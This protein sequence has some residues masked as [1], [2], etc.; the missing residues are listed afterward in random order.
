MSGSSTRSFSVTSIFAEWRKWTWPVL[1]VLLVGSIGYLV[2]N[3]DSGLLQV[4]A[5]K[6]E[7]DQLRQ[8]VVRL[9]A[10]RDEL[11]SQIKRLEKVDPL[12]IEEEARR[13]GMVREGEEV[14]RLQ[15]EETPDSTKTG[16]VS[17]HAQER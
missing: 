10:E 13:K 3:H 14:Y 1:L 12:V 2:L 9:Q 5:L 15:Y 8:E 7:R 16:S 11:E 6:K 4:L 17:P